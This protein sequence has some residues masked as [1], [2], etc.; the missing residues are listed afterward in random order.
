MYR[1]VEAGLVAPERYVQI[2]LRGY[3]PGEEVFAWQA[4][5]GITSFFMHE[6]RE[7]R[8]RCRS[9]RQRSSASD[10]ARSF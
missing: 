8:H 2:G 3:W 6:V 10:R 4:E 7:Q 5:R 1:L 9:W